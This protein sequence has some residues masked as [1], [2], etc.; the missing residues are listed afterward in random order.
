MRQFLFS[1]LVLGLSACA[2]P[3]VVLD[4]GANAVKVAKSDP[5]DNF[6]EVGPVSGSHGEGCGAFGYPGTYEGAVTDI[7]NNAHKMQANYVQ[8][9]TI[10]EPHFRPG[11]FDNLYKLSGTGYRKVREMPSPTPIVEQHKKMTTHEKLAE[12]QGLRSQNLISADEYE[13][14]RKQILLQAY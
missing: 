5:S 2:S 8:I 12:L 13:S 9:F 3:N 11:C 14:L 6:E 7:K 1:V 4:P 10:V